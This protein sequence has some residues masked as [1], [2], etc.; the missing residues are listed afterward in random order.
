VSKQI[1]K[2]ATFNSDRKQINLIPKNHSDITKNSHRLFFDA[3]VNSWYFIFLTIVEISTLHE[4]SLLGCLHYLNLPC[5]NINSI[6]IFRV[7]ISTLN[8]IFLVGISTLP[9]YS[10]LEYLLY[11]NIPCWNIYSTW[12]FLVGIYTL[13]EY[14]VLEYL[15]YLNMPCWNARVASFPGPSTVF[16]ETNK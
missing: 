12:I 5:W 4:Y 8:W 15:L 1:K 3:F 2:D 6:W 14:S 10:V 11:L 7:G 13:L 9:K 16:P